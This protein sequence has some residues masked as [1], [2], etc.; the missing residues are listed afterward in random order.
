V[1]SRIYKFTLED[2]PHTVT[3]EYSLLTGWERLTVDDN[4]ISSGFRWTLVSHYAFEIAD[5]SCKLA[6]QLGFTDGSCQL[7][8]DGQPYELL[9]EQSY[10]RAASAPEATSSQELLRPATETGATPP[11]ELLRASQDDNRV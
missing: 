6:F 1:P 8:I 4:V 3:L 5:H 11:D 2:G 9:P 7:T 10:L